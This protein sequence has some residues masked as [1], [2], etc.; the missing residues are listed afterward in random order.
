MAEDSGIRRLRLVGGVTA[1]NEEP[2]IERSLRSLLEQEMPQGLGWT[3]IWVVVSGC[4]DRTAEVVERLS[5]EDPRI[6]L[7][8]EPRRNGKASALNEIF[9][10]A[11][12]DLL[13]LLDGDS[14][15]APGALR[16]MWTAARSVEPPFAVMG[17]PAPP[18]PPVG[19]IYPEV[20]LLY[21]L[22]HEYH[23]EVLG[24]GEGTHLA[25][26][27]M[28]LSL[29]S[30]PTL[31]RNLVNDGPFLAHWV[32]SH[33]G[34]L[35]YAPQAEV[36]LKIPLTLGDHLAQRRR[37]HWGH[38]QVR[39]LTGLPVTTLETHARTRPGEAWKIVVR[40]VRSTR[41]GSRSLLVLLMAEVAAL[42]MARWDRVSPRP[43]PAL[44]LPIRD[45]LPTPERTLF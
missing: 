2:R 26:N 36:I 28:L 22:H 11:D 38:W 19:R 42:A 31:P 9:S 37:I 13:V 15:A 40:S 7:V 34:R 35:L 25:D 39:D 43:E 16:S 44:W 5:R 23:A 27:L 18:G 6:V 24:R 41:K 10:R 8:A 30:R 17:R 21:R 45:S 33:G 29:G 20:E 3:K 4:T 12:G 14:V 32:L 1:Y